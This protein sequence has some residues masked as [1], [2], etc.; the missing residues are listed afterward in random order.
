MRGRARARARAHHEKRE[1]DIAN[2]K[3]MREANKWNEQRA[4]KQWWN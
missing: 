2:K 4:Y 1:R 3:G